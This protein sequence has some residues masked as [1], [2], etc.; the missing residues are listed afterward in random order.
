M[1][2]PTI[3]IHLELKCVRCGKKGAMLTPTGKANI[4]LRCCA[5]AVTA[6]EFDHLWKKSKP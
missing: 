2:T 3:T 6:G 5:K 1:R 4:C